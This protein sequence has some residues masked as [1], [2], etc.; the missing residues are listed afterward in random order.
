MGSIET[1]MSLIAGAGDSKSYSME[2]ISHARRAEFDEARSCLKEAKSAMV[3]V[4]EIQTSL[5]R[6]EMSGESSELSL[7]M[8][9]AQSHLASAML[10]RDM[11]K[12]FLELYEKIYLI[13]EHKN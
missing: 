5:I 7:L 12:E 13:N 10:M 11:A 4:H 8:V 2:A 9:H 6:S 1:A 3:E